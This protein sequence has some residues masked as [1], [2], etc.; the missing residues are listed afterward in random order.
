MEKFNKNI[1][2]HSC[3]LDATIL[4]IC[5]AFIWFDR[6]LLL[7]IPEGRIFIFYNIFN[8]KERWTS[9]WKTKLRNCV[10]FDFLDLNSHFGNGVFIPTKL[11]CF[12][13]VINVTYLT[14]NSNSL[15]NLLSV[16]D[17]FTNFFILC[18]DYCIVSQ[19]IQCILRVT[20]IHKITAYH[21]SCSPLKILL[22]SL[23]LTLLF[24]LCSELPQRFSRLF[25]TKFSITLN[26]TIW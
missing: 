11:Q 17:K 25:Q 23:K 22:Y 26:K 14:W 1:T 24:L 12:F 10:Q 2:T 13:K 5:L 20:T 16:Q 4:Y 8:A 18:A 6:K 3:I 19:S 15:L 21:N 7:R 9:S